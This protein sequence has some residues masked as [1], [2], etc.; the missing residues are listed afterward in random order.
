MTKAEIVAKIAEKTGVEKG[1]AQAVVESFMEIV[2]EAVKKNEDVYLRGFGSF[3]SKKRAA[4]VG[5][6]IRANGGAG[7]PI[8]IPEHNIPAF[9]P[10]KSFI[11]DLK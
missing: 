10:A 1:N 3:K 7:A 9:K 8:V 2:K 5:R 11:N 6:N 4:K